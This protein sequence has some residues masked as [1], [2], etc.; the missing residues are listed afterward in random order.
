MTVNNLDIVPSFPMFARRRRRP[1][2]DLVSDFA[3]KCIFRAKSLRGASVVPGCLHTIAARHDVSGD[4]AGARILLTP[5][6]PCPTIC[7]VA[8][9][10]PT[11]RPTTTIEAVMTMTDET[12]TTY[13][14]AGGDAPT[15]PT[16]H[17]IGNGHIDPVWLWPWPEGF[18]EITA[19]FHA[20]LDR[21]AEND[22]FIFTA[23]SAAM[24]EWVEKQQPAMFEEIKLRVEEGRWFIV[25]G[26]W[27]QPD[28]NLPSGESFVRQALYGQR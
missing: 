11:N 24:Y 23:S 15:R 18:H 17:M 10:G 1:S 5:S 22:D 25:G 16:L 13:G 20:A 26:W 28:C 19:T 8:R 6:A 2:V 14:A 9:S 4:S 21:I 12:P 7:W 27:I 3:P